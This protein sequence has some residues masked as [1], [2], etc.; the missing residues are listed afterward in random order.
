MP[1]CFHCGAPKRPVTE[2][3]AT[4]WVCTNPICKEFNTLLPTGS[5]ARQEET[6]P[7]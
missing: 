5:I 1:T 4:D 6:D 3:G 2:K 7:F